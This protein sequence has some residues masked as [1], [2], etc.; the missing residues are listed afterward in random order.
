MLSIM[1]DK[2]CEDGGCSAVLLLADAQGQASMTLRR[3]EADE[4]VVIA[5]SKFVIWCKV[6]RHGVQCRVLGWSGLMRKETSL[7]LDLEGCDQK[8]NQVQ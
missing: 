7:R 8:S 5:R 3:N 6:G 4:F 2:D 1:L